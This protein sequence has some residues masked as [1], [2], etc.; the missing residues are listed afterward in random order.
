MIKMPRCEKFRMCKNCKHF[1]PKSEVK[2]K[3]VLHNMGNLGGVCNRPKKRN[4]DTVRCVD[5]EYDHC[6][7]FEKKDGGN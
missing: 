1:L 2:S 3:W 6:S 4:K 7:M 5:E